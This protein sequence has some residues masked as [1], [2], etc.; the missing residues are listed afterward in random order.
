[1]SLNLNAT[2]VYPRYDLVE[3]TLQLLDGSGDFTS[4]WHDSSGVH[5]LRV[6]VKFL[7]G[8]SPT[9]TIEEAQWDTSNDPR[10][11]RSQSVPISSLLGAADLNIT[12]RWFRVKIDAGGSNDYCAYTMRKVA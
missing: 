5:T 4:D 6:A 7:S 8:S 12:A 9:F 11:I 10:V 2:D 1:M 3:E